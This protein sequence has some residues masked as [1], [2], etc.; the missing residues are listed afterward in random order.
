MRK[1]GRIITLVLAILQIILSA[2]LVVD[3]F[4]ILITLSD[5]IFA[6][7][8]VVNG[9]KFDT[10]FLIFI[11]SIISLYLALTHVIF[12]LKNGLGTELYAWSKEKHLQYLEARKQKKHQKT[13]KHKAK[14]QEKLNKLNNEENE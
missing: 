8:L 6:E 1:T 5:F 9:L 7:D 14:L 13:E 11:T 2:K 3:F 10:Y 12:T 4:V